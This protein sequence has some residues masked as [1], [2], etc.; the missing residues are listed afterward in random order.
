M[1][2]L[3]LKHPAYVFILGPLGR[4]DPLVLRFWLNESSISRLANVLVVLD[5]GADHGEEV[6]RVEGQGL[7]VS[8]HL[9]KG[10][11]DGQGALKKWLGHL[12]EKLKR[13]KIY[14]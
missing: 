2:L 1:W 11:L 8:K 7:H 12:E 3:L 10:L 5:S 13:K 6:L 14:I 9:V 4:D